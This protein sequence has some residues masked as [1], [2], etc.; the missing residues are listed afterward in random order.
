MQNVVLGILFF[1]GGVITVAA[2]SVYVT[3]TGTKYHK[4]SCF[5]LMNSKRALDL[6]KAT[7]LEYEACKHCKPIGYETATTP[8]NKPKITSNNPSATVQCA[9]KT[10]AGSRCKRK[11]TNSSG[12]CY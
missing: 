12:R 7:S 4:E 10:K 3:S 1:L 11:T 9:G 6:K 5:H 2:Q 8:T